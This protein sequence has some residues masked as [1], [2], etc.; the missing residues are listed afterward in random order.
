MPRYA[1]VAIDA[2]LKRVVFG[3]NV[4]SEFRG[5]NVVFPEVTN[6]LALHDIVYTIV[7]YGDI[8][9]LGESKQ[10]YRIV[11]GVLP[12]PTDGGVLATNDLYRVRKYY[13]FIIYNF[14][15]K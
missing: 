2:G 10:P 12:L 3:V 5:E 14:Q 13:R 8:K 6:L 7:K 1:Q 9:P 15:L 11:R 4:A